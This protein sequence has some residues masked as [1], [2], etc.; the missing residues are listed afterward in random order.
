MILIPQSNKVEP[1][2][3]DSL[4]VIKCP[5]YIRY[6]DKNTACPSKLNNGGIGEDVLKQQ[7]I[8]EQS[9][10]DSLSNSLSSLIDGGNTTLMI[11]EI[12]TSLTPRC[13]ITSS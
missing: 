2:V 11:N 1:F 10:I 9:Q 4:V 8:F 13:E 7:Y 12:Q 5:T 3:I 6:I